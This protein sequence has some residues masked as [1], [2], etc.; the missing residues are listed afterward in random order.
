MAILVE[1]QTMWKILVYP[2]YVSIS[3]EQVEHCVGMGTN[4]LPGEPDLPG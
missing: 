4:I 2:V 3:G 1:I